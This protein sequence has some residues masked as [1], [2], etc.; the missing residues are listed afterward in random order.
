M[1]AKGLAKRPLDSVRL[2]AGPPAPTSLEPEPTPASG[3]DELF[4][5][6][7][8]GDYEDAEPWAAVHL[9]QRIGTRQVFDKA[10]E[11]ADSSAPLVRAR[12][13]DV[14][15][16]L[17]TTAA[18]R[19][20]AFP[21]ESFDV[22]VKAA[23]KERVVRP[24]N[25]AISALG[26]IGDPRA[27]PL[28]AAFHS[29]QS[30]EVRFSVAFALGCFPDEPLSVQT[31]LTLMEDADARVRDWATFALGVLGDQDSPEIRSALLHRLN[32]EGVDTR[33]EALVGLAKRHD[34]RIL[35]QLI[36]ELGKPGFSDRVV[37]AANA[38]LGFDSHHEG[39]SG[40]DYERSL[41]ELFSST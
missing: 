35:P 3:I 40:Q 27:V 16:Q 39:W 25:S 4:T 32:D 33:E 18:H 10:V 7:L 19:S 15:A 24:L 9:L 41:R 26:H 17:G 6:T 21:R 23:Q 5:Q 13:L 31:I 8:Q 20:N 2:H 30:E 36:H 22:V 29:H 28:I 34:T 14:I 12:G 11:W 38:M 1:R 37:E